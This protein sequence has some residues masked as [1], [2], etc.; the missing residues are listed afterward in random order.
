M[1]EMKTYAVIG[2]NCFT[3]AH[4]TDALLEDPNCRVVGVSRSPQP[5]ALFLPYRG[6]E[7]GRFE[8]HQ[9]DVVRQGEDLLKLL[10]STRPEA[11]IWVAALS[12]VALSLELPLEYFETNT[13]AVVRATDHLRRQGYL[14]R[15]IQISTA[16][17]YGTCDRPAGEDARLNPSTPYAASKAAADLHI[18]ALARTFGFPAVLVRSTNVYGKHQQLYKIIPRTLIRLRR[19]ETIELHGGGRAVKSWIHIRDVARGVLSVLRSGRPG[20]VYHFTDANVLSIAE[21]V[22]RI[23]AAAGRDF[24]RCVREVP[25]RPGQ[26]A[27]YVLD[28]EKSRRD[29]EWAPQVP[30]DEGLK[31]VQAWLDSHLGE[32]SQQPLEYAHK[33]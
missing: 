9:I 20:E 27:R 6:R 19:G 1:K 30:F 29:L 31:E 18:L 32:I 25:E 28:D 14:R 15:Y 12:E 26:D 33:P 11:V 21:L 3:G 22:R 17:V 16:E 24:D 10:D 8:F 13:L 7:G 2:S 5:E 4:L 23:C